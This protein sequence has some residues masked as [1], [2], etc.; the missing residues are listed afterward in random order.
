MCR[1]IVGSFI[2]VQVFRII[3]RDGLLKYISKSFRTVGSTFSFSV[4]DAEVCWMNYL[5]HP[6][7]YFGELRK[8]LYAISVVMM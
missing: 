5:Q 8:C 7:F 2:I 4:S 3:F 6:R 1:H